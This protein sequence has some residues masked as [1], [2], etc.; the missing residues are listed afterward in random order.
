M[1]SGTHTTPVSHVRPIADEITK[2]F[3]ATII[4]QLVEEGKIRLDGKITDYITDYPKATGDKIT[5]SHLLTHSS[6]I[7]GYTE[8]G[9]KELAIKYYEKSLELDPKS[10]S[11][12]DALK[13]FNRR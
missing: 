2:Q 12:I 7:P 3:T 11:G 8:A 1:L 6:G 4:L 13:K 5:V 10:Q 9:E